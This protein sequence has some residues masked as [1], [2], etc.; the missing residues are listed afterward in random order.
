M[1]DAV[2]VI[3]GTPTVTQEAIVP[4]DDVITPRGRTSEENDAKE[5]NGAPTYRDTVAS[6]PALTVPLTTDERLM[7]LLTVLW[8]ASPFRHIAMFNVSIVFDW[9]GVGLSEF[10]QVQTAY[11]A[12]HQFASGIWG[13][14][15]S[16]VVLLP[17]ADGRFTRQQLWIWTGP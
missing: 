11:N 16:K 1:S 10:N 6:L 8:D 4:S 15:T 14:I 5:H 3:A 17:F 13:E 2:H 9:Q 12:F 7:R